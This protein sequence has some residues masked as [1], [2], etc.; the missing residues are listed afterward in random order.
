MGPLAWFALAGLLLPPTPCCIAIFILRRKVKG[1]VGG[2]IDPLF[3]SLCSVVLVPAFR[4][5]KTA[6]LYVLSEAR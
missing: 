3:L 4:T 2:I 5:A 1:P 6:A